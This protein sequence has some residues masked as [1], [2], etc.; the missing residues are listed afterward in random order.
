VAKYSGMVEGACSPSGAS[1]SITASA[2][3]F[4]ISGCWRNL[5][6]PG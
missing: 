3:F 4:F 6:N 5:D 1:I 2:L